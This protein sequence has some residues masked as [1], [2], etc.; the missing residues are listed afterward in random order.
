V[1]EAGEG[2]GAALSKKTEEKHYT[3]PDG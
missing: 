1:K 3:G 2:L